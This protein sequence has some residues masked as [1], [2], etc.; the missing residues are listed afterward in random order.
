MQRTAD[1]QHAA[2]APRRAARAYAFAAWVA[3]AAVVGLC[4]FANAVD[5]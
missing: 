4:K 5:P 1:I 2:R 3:A